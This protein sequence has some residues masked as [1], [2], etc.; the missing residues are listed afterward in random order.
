VLSSRRFSRLLS[1]VAFLICGAPPQRPG[2]F[3]RSR[4]CFQRCGETFIDSAALGPDTLKVIGQAFDQAWDTIAGNFEGNPLAIQAA[5]LKLANAILA[6][7]TANCHDDVETLKNAALQ[8][9]ALAYRK[10]DERGAA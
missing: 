1:A 9:M 5:R 4:G 7:A 2:S 6:E 3:H 10:R 8:A